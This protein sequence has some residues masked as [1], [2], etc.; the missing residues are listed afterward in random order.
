MTE[1]QTPEQTEQHLGLAGKT[2]H[3]FI[4]SPLTPLLL[5]GFLAMGLMGLLMTPR[6]EDPQISV[7][8]VDIF[9]SYQGATSEHGSDQVA[10]APQSGDFSI[11]PGERKDQGSG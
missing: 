1:E 7:P 3:A 10:V 11:H 5:F 9:V 6:Q 8:M 4:Q 2:A